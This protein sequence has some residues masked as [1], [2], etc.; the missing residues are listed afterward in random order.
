[1]L[2]RVAVLLSV[3]SLAAC[4]GGGY[5]EIGGGGG[6]GGG[7]SNPRPNPNPNPPTLSCSAAGLAASAAS[8]WGTVCMLTSSGEIVVELYDSYAPQTVANFY[9]YVAAG[10]YS[11]TLIHRVDRDFVVQGGGY[12]SGMIE[13]QP[14]YAPIKLESNNN[15]SNLRGTIAMA[16]RSDADSATS[17]FFFNVVDN[18]GLD[19]QSAS[20]PGYAVFGRI[21]SGLNTLDAINIVPVYRYSSTDLQPQTEVLVYW[22]QRLK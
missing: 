4:G 21:I 17:Q 1:M 5:V 8:Q 9:K 13:K 11:N 14:L 10:F 19:Y 15:L 20:N 18:T 2:R 7:G 22:A 3:L 12:R 16:R 6:G